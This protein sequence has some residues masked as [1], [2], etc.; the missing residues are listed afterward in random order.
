VSTFD[1]ALAAVLKEEG[2]FVNDS[3][4]PGGMTNLGVTKQTWEAYTRKPATTADMK[5][6]TPAKVAPLYRDRYWRVAGCDV[7]P[8]ALALC[9]FDFAVNAGPGRAAK[10][11][12]MISGSSADGQV[13]P[14]TL[15]AVQQAVAAKGLPEI[16]RR[17]MNARRD[18][19]RSLP[20]FG[21]FGKGWLARCDRMETQALRMCK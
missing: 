13:G 15:K 6:L 8:P 7:M 11:L 1:D 20:N 17:Y 3:R 5:A 16:I 9:V 19:Y 10:F 21:V 12:Q 14:A 2:G 4:D 18:Y